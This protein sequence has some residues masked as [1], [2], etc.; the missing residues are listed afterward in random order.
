MYDNQ[1]E[2][3]INSADQEKAAE[4]AG[5]I[6]NA[7]EMTHTVISAD[8]KAEEAFKAIR[9]PDKK[10]K[11]DT[12]QKYLKVYKQFIN[13]SAWLTNVRV[14]SVD[15]TFYDTVEIQELN[16]QLR[17]VVGIVY[18][19]DVYHTAASKM[20]KECLKKLAKNTGVLTDAQLELL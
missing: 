4:L 1:M 5:Y 9:L 13:E 18:L 16:R 7:V 6:K 19:R 12:L 8:Q 20:V 14:Y 3:R 17:I 2:Q 10:Y 15:R 11:W